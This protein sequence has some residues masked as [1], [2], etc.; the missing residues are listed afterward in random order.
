MSSTRDTTECPETPALSGLAES[1]E[2]EILAYVETLRRESLRA[3][4]GELEE[5]SDADDVSSARQRMRRGMERLLENVRRAWQ[6]AGMVRDLPSDAVIALTALADATHDS[7]IRD[8]ARRLSALSA[9]VGELEAS[10]RAL[11]GQS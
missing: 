7:A 6:E 4:L 2:N 3:A 10:A 5:A 8:I 1:T 9:A 11:Q